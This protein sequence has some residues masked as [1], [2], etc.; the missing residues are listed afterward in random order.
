MIRREAY[1]K[2][3]AYDVRLTNLQDFDMWIRMLVAG[4]NIH[5]MPE[6]LT[7]FRIR[8]NNA[9]ASAPSPETRLRGIYKSAKILGRFAEFDEGLFEEVFGEDTNASAAYKDPVG[10]RVAVLARRIPRVDYQNFA[11]GLIYELARRPEDFTRLRDWGG[12]VDALNI[13]AV[14]ERDRRIEELN[15]ALEYRDSTILSLA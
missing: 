14:E 13:R 4:H 6:K 7:A 3:G 2:V 9:N 1:E 5:V 15:Q 12:S 8:A 10:F 11:L